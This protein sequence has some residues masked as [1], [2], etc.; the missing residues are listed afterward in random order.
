MGVFDGHSS[1]DEEGSTAQLAK[2]LGAPVILV[3]DAS[4]VARSVAAE[5]LG[6]QQFD[7]AM[8]IAGV[9]LNGVASPAHLDFCKPQIEAT[10]GI[11]VLGYLPRR[12][13]FEQPERHLGLI[14]TVEGTVARQWYDALI[15]QVEETIDVD[16]I[17]KLSETAESPTSEARVYPAGTATAPVRY[18]R[19]PG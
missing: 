7:P 14:P 6:Y 4:K 1:L 2:L 17:V 9:I 5:V 3:A 8:R 12:E 18:C 16:R 15:A 19:G 10:T 11:P 13:I